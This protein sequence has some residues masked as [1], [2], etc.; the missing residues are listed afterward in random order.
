MINET[1]QVVSIDVWRE[2]YDLIGLDSGELDALW[3]DSE[4]GRWNI[5][6]LKGVTPNKVVAAIRKKVK[7]SGL[8]EDLD[9]EVTHNDRDPANGSYMVSVLA[10]PEAKALA[11]KSANMLAEEGVQGTTLLESLLLWLAY[12]LATGKCLDSE[13]VTLC[14][15]SR[16]SDGDV[17]GVDWHPDGCNV[18]VDWHCPDYWGGYLSARSIS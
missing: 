2:V 1:A 16:F 13:Q 5:P 7:V 14:S 10:E 11:N 17:P 9:A 15:G 3:N 4:P 12:Y 18:Y 6:V 8:I